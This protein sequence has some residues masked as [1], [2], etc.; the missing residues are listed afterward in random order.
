MTRDKM[1]AELISLTE[2]P[3]GQKA[4]EPMVTSEE[5]HSAKMATGV[6]AQR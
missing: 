6:H 3:L 5:E 2:S 4:T 1:L